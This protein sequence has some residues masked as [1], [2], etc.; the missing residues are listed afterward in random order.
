MI[1][2]YHEAAPRLGLAIARA[3]SVYSTLPA[4]SSQ[5]RRFTAPCIFAASGQAYLTVYTNL[6]L[7]QSPSL[8]IL[9]P[10]KY[11]TLSA[12]R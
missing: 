7:E 6:A 12:C 3:S 8:H 11:Q 2:W 1:F 10:N 9:E 5:D 4:S